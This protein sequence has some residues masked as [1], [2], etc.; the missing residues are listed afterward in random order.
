M[1]DVSTYLSTD[2]VSLA[3]E[4]A[5]NHSPLH[6]IL[7][8]YNISEKQ[9]NVIKSTPVFRDY[10]EQQTSEWN[11]VANTNERIKYKSAALLELWLEEANTRLHD[12][13]Q[14]LA[15]K[16]ELAKFIGRLAGMG[17]TGANINDAGGGSKLTVTINLGSDSKLTFEKEMAPKVLEHEPTE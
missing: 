11:S 9:W 5:M 7:G 6:E 15:P 10:L 4:I 12:D 1:N 2:L 3:R 14:Q 16:V 8:R 17:I 13:R